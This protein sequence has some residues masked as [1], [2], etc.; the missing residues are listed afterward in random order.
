MIVVE[1][2]GSKF[3]SLN[4]DQITPSSNGNASRSNGIRNVVVS[5]DLNSQTPPN[6]TRV[7]NGG[8]RTRHM[9][10]HSIGHTGDNARNR[11]FNKYFKCV[12]KVTIWH[13][14]Q[15]MTWF[16][17]SILLLNLSNLPNLNW[18]L[19]K[20]VMLLSAY[21]WKYLELTF[22]IKLLFIL[23]LVIKLSVIYYVLVNKYAK[24][25]EY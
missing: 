14:L 9:A 20:N 3:T 18:R 21:C 19:K 10:H 16:L 15:G 5:Q 24:S 17:K 4:L 12:W 22:N 6:V 11:Y 1:Q 7:T 2:Y 8:R 25:H 13:W 23:K